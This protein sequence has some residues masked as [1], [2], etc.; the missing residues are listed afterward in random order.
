MHR[1]ENGRN[2]WSGIFVLLAC[3]CGLLA[4]A[5]SAW[6]VASADWDQSTKTLRFTG[7]VSG[8]LEAT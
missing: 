1:Q 2:G 6:A 3:L 5:E 8:D 4:G 7:L